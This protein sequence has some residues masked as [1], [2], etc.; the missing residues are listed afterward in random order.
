[1]GRIYTSM[2][3]LIGNTPMLELTK[4]AK[5]TGCCAR[6]LAK[7]EMY[8]PGGSVKDR[9]ARSMLDAAALT[10]GAAF[11]GNCGKQL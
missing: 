10:P 3:Q 8:N 5:E 6:L 1:M 2:E 11:C 7:L 4:F 9:V